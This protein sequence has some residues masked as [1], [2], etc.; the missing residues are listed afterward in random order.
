MPQ[1]LTC[2]LLFSAQSMLDRNVLVYRQLIIQFGW[3]KLITYSNM[4]EKTRQKVNKILYHEIDSPQM[5]P[6]REICPPK[7]SLILRKSYQI[8]P[9][10]ILPKVKV[11][12]F[13]NIKLHQF[14]R[15]T[16]YP[17]DYSNA[18]LRL[19]LLKKIELSYRL[20]RF[21]RKKSF[22]L[23]K[24]FARFCKSQVSEKSVHLETQN[25]VDGFEPTINSSVLIGLE[26][27]F[28]KSHKSTL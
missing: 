19:Y 2:S 25:C 24:H 16:S 5:A 6:K 18:K 28:L 11:G 3:K 1:I 12:K 17:V 8:C 9:A 10:S 21:F 23:I 4:S 7:L 14:D 27:A 13:Y 26:K 15:Q 22:F 20:L